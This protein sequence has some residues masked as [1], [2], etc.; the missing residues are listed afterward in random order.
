[1]PIYDYEILKRFGLKKKTGEIEE[2][3]DD[4]L[5]LYHNIEIE[6]QNMIQSDIGKK[7]IEKFDEKIP[8]TNI[9]DIKKVKKKSR[10]GTIYFIL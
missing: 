9:T 1:M 6:M 3:F 5:D 10:N 8:H 2:R 7:L 4:A